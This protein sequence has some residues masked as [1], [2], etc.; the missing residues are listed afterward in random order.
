[1]N[2]LKEGVPSRRS[3]RLR[4][5]GIPFLLALALPACR[6]ETLLT[7]VK[8]PDSV[9][10]PP[11]CQTADCAAWRAAPAST[12]A[13]LVTRSNELVAVLGNPSLRSGLATPL[14]RMAEALG[15]G[16]SAIAAISL[17]GALSVIDAG[18][19]DSNARGDWAD[20][21]AIRLNLEPLIVQ[22]G[23]R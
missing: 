21:S 17:L 7:G 18:L 14:T 15:R 13:P 9:V 8:N 2:V 19:T 16:D 4:T 6:D 20:L 3:F 1:M 5:V 23:L 12:M 22:L 11:A 10:Q